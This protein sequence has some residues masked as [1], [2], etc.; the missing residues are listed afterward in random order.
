MFFEKFPNSTTLKEN[1]QGYDYDN[2]QLY[3]IKKQSIKFLEFEKFL[4]YT[5]IQE[6]GQGYDFATGQL[7]K[8]EKNP[9]VFLSFKNISTLQL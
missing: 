6:N 8:I 5:T 4:N 7:Y 1:G 3:K 9:S 2:D